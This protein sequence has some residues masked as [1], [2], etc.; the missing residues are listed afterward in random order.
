[1]KPRAQVGAHVAHT[2]YGNPDA[3]EG[4]L[5]EPRGYGCPDAVEYTECGPR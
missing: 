3:R 5:A 4:V 2:L 1:M